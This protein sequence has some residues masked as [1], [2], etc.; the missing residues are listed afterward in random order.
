MRW[1]IW[2]PSVASATARNR[3][4]GPLPAVTHGCIVW[5]CVVP[6]LDR[7]ISIE[8]SEPAQAVVIVPGPT[9][10][11]EPFATVWRISWFV[12][13]EALGLERYEGSGGLGHI[14]VYLD[15]NPTQFAS[16]IV[17][18]LNQQRWSYNVT[19]EQGDA[20]AAAFN[21]VKTGLIFATVSS[22]AVFANIGSYQINY[23][24]RVRDNT[25]REVGLHPASQWIDAKL[26]S[27]AEIA[28]VS[29]TT[30]PAVQAASPGFTGAVTYLHDVVTVDGVTVGSRWLFPLAPRWSVGT[31]DLFRDN[32][33]PE[34]V[35]RADYFTAAGGGPAATWYVHDEVTFTHSDLQ[36]GVP[37]TLPDLSAP[38]VEADPPA[39]VDERRRTI[40][41]WAQIISDLSSDVLLLTTAGDDITDQAIEVRVRVRYDSR[42][43]PYSSVTLGGQGFDIVSIAEDVTAGARRRFQILGLRR[44]QFRA[45]YE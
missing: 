41:T 20:V 33:I 30:L 39:E 19:Q 2:R 26:L 16:P 15:R 35:T 31:V 29:F 3:G 14:M 5:A 7:P 9:P 1:R 12:Q 13:T 34:P 8:L 22:Y 10:S 27:P 37:L 45:L 28:D 40:G 17:E 11:D 4:S 43:N 23:G 21:A 18:P 6:E 42:I 32:R 24:P 38:G 25:N 44:R 36:N